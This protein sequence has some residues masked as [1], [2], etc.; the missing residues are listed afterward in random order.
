ML[1]AMTIL[2][3]NLLANHIEYGRRQELPLTL[4]VSLMQRTNL[5]FC[6]Y[7]TFIRI[8][9]AGWVAHSSAAKY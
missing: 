7:A 9:A 3:R 1:L 4:S 5:R 8:R 6:G 2:Q